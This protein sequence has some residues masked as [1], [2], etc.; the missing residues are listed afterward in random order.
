MS[1]QEKNT[2]QP[3][4]IPEIFLQPYN[5][6]EH[7]EKTYALWESSGYFN[8]DTC[9][10]DG[11]ADETKEAFS[12]VLPPPNVTGTLHMGHAA[13]LAIEDILVR[14]NRMLGKPTLWLP[15]TDSAAIATQSKVEKM[16][17]KDEGK[18]RYDLGRDELLRR[19]NAFAEES[20][21]TII[22]QT[23]HM[24]SS[25]D[26]SRYAFTLDESR[27][28]AVTT[29]FKRMYDAGL[30]YRGARIVNWDP[31]G[32]T[33]ISDDEIIYE[34][35]TATMYTF[36]YSK[37]FPIPI[38]TT[39][40]ETKVGDTAVAVHPD[41]E[42]YKAY[43]GKEYDVVFCDVPL[44][45]KVVADESVEKDFGTGALGVTPAHSQVDWE[46]ADRH[47]L[48]RPQVINEYAKMTVDG[49]LNG[50][51]VG[52]ARETVV[53]FLREE[54][55]LQKEEAISQNVST[56]ERTGAIIEPLPK[57]QWWIDVNKEFTMGHSEIP[58]VQEGDTVTLK[59]LMHTAVTGGGV[60][61]FPDRFERV[62]DN[63]IN[64]LRDWCISRQIWYGH[65]IPVWYK[66]NAEGRE[67]A[68][69]YRTAPQSSSSA[70]FRGP[71]ASV[72][73]SPN[74]SPS[75]SSP[76][77]ASEAP[78]GYSEL[79]IFCGTEAPEGEGWEQDS[80]TLDTWFSSGLWTFSTLGWP[81]ETADMKRYHPTTLLETGYDILFFWVA[82]MVLMSTFH[83]GQVPFKHVYLHGLVRD[84]KG[85]KMS[86]SLGNVMDPL[87]MIEKYGADATRLSLIIGAAPGNDV[88][89][90]EDKVR[91][92]K[93]FANKVWN[94]SRFILTNIADADYSISPTLSPRDTEILA[95]LHTAV[96]EITADIEKYHLYLAAEKT[97]HYI[98]HELADVILEE[99]KPILNGE[100]ASARAA[101]QHVLRECLITTIK[102]LH[103]F[104]P[105]V[106]ETIWQNLPEE[107]RGDERK[108]LMVTRWPQG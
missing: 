66:V 92:Y 10:K 74:T 87:D 102:V 78:E 14:Y 89:L 96:R 5:A 55:L 71:D 93:H 60:T 50:K 61:I 56:A 79:E 67:G 85:K 106:T 65:R 70:S 32:Q 28:Q 86:K 23:K 31:K 13:M 15:G 72:T 69:G 82:R 29:A 83:L 16:I 105:Y 11:I 58:G 6:Q 88:P 19:V 36:T 12:I 1:E 107:V 26:W 2:Q 43:V 33:T 84:A 54:G 64:N 103:P 63:W 51:K 108:M 46:I 80:D 30:I 18:S 45:I 75:S 98:W 62:Y 90:A 40:P 104:M 21:N 34:E 76:S 8:P 91:G 57:L 24:G 20:K 100:D 95:G 97:Y 101:R 41:D 38:S 49:R 27:Y 3:A 52:E 59:T 42:R 4:Q 25:L 22:N 53:A 73:V 7:E 35:R 81:N 77:L 68:L 48:P 99:S 47:S 39:R 17:Y 94:I 37:D 44:H 9:I